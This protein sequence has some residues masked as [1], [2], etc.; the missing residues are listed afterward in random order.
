MHT[1]RHPETQISLVPGV[2]K[3]AC[4]PKF[5]FPIMNSNNVIFN[6]FD[7]HFLHGLGIRAVTSYAGGGTGNPAS[8]SVFVNMT[9]SD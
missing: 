8:N 3:P 7:H 6:S 5:V 4:T 9:L 2:V 1:Y